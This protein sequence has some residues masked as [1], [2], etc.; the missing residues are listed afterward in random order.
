MANG[1]HLNK[2]HREAVL[3]NG[4]KSV[5]LLKEHIHELAQEGAKLG[6]DE[7]LHLKDCDDC[8]NQFRLFVL[9]RFYMERTSR[10]FELKCQPI[11]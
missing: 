7:R 9:Q 6:R 3:R 10:P 11:R 8:A 2:S 1:L 4:G 5:H